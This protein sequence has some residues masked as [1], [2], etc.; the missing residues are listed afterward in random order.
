MNKMQQGF[1]LIELMIVVAIIGILA[2]VALPAYRDYTVRATVAALI[3]DLGGQKT[4][5]SEEYLTLANSSLPSAITKARDGIT[6]TLTP[7]ATTN[8]I[9]W[10]CSVSGTTVDVSK[11][12]N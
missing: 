12:C 9:A 6:I 10:G 5:L 7:S 8:G 1:T 3:A 4:K 2:A 11:I